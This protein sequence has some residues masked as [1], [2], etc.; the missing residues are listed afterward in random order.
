M[1]VLF[2]NPLPSSSE[3]QSLFLKI[4]ELADLNENHYRMIYTDQ[5]Y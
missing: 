2:D 3:N 5:N 4:G 1:C